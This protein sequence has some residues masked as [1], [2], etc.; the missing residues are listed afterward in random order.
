MKKKATKKQKKQL[1]ILVKI[2]YFG[3]PV[4]MILEMIF[5]EIH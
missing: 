4:Q 2:V 5:K 1:Y 3:N